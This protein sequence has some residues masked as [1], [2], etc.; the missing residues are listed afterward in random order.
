M[1]EK[2]VLGVEEWRRRRQEGELVTLPSGMVARLRRIHILDL[3]EQGEIPA[4][5]ATLASE[6]VSASRTN[7]N[8]GA[9]KRYGQIVNRVV[10]AAMVEPRVGD[11]PT[12][13]QLAVDEL[14]MLDRLAIF[15]YG[16]V[17]TRSLRLFRPEQK[18]S[19]E[20]A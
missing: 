19:V 11:E 6:L 10:R 14:E 9:M 12:K 1:D 15:N 3:V 20:S 16:N 5:L 18:E 4:S 17:S 8:A 2:Y 7:L 13:E